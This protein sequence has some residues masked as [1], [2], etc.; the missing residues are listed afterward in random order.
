MVSCD[1][2]FYHIVSIISELS[3]YR[4]Q[5]LS[6]K[7]Y[8]S[9]KDSMHH[10]SRTIFSKRPYGPCVLPFIGILSFYCLFIPCV[11]RPYAHDKTYLL[12]HRLQNT[13]IAIPLECTVPT[14]VFA[15]K[16]MKLDI[17]LNQLLHW[18]DQLSDVKWEYLMYSTLKEMPLHS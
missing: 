13:K 2:M 17:S 1:F 4:P 18:A 15:R 5:I 8:F 11:K 9:L 14:Q 10:N 16:R 3:F 12:G 7:W 6:S